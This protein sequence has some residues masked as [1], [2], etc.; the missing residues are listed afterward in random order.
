[1]RCPPA[2]N[3]AAEEETSDP[4]TPTPGVRMHVREIWVK[5]RS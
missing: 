2:L 4:P 1:M 3:D 5:R